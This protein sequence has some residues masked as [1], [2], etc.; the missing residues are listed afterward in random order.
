MRGRNYAATGWG[1]AGRVM[2]LKKAHPQSWEHLFKLAAE[3]LA[4]RSKKA[5]AK[6]A[7]KAKKAV[8]ALIYT[9]QQTRHP[10]PRNSISAM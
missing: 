4:A 10:R 7:K 3:K 6:K 9:P 5:K 8:N 1:E 2:R